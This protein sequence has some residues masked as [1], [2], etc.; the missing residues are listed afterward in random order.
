MSSSNSPCAA[1]KFLRRKCTQEC[2]FAPNFPPDQPQRFANVHKVFGASN[3]AKLLNELSAVQ[4]EDAVNS[5]AYEAEARLRDP[6]YGCVGLISLLQQRLKQVQ[7]DLVGAKKELATYIGPS[8]LVAGGPPVFGYNVG[9]TAVG[10]Y[11]VAAAAAV[12]PS[13]VDV[14]AAREAQH[15]QVQ[16]QM[17][18]IEEQ[19]LAALAIKEEQEIMRSW[20]QQQQLL[21]YNAGGGGGG[22]GGNYEMGGGVVVAAEEGGGYVQME[23]PELALGAGTFDPSNQNCVYSQFQQQQQPQQ[24]ENDESLGQLLI[25]QQPETTAP[26]QGHHLMLHR[27]EHE[28]VQQ[29]RGGGSEEGGPGC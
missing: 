1:C 15:Q 21:R 28:Q 29:N 8:A 13:C 26:Q 6:V 23:S 12:G 11:N 16:Q 27:H 2:I 5:L 4:R 22:F 19:Q 10:G 20:E 24:Q 25:L 14:V 9:P 17:Q 7:S 3:V 18:L